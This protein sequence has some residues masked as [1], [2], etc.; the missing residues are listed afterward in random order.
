MIT[1]DGKDFPN[2]WL[3]LGSGPHYVK[4][5]INLDLNTFEGWEHQPDILGSV[6][7][8]PMIPDGSMDKVYCGHLLEHLYWE[9]VPSA[10]EEIKRVMAPEGV[11]CVVGPCMDKAIATHQPQWLLDE[12]PAGWNDGTTNPDELEGFPHRWTATTDLTREALETTF[13]KGKI[14]EV[15]INHIKLPEWCNTAQSHPPAGAGMWQCSFLV[16]L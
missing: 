11:L 9:T 2:N 1:I 5:W 3:H 14:R 8:M 7:D 16:T 13:E 6:Y 15:P 10:L 12:I 4:G